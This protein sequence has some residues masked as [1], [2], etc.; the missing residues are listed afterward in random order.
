VGF[1]IFLAFYLLIKS[2]DVD[3]GEDTGLNV[4][5]TIIPAIIYL[6]ENQPGISLGSVLGE[7]LTSGRLLSLQLSPGT[8]CSDLQQSD[9]FFDS[10]KKK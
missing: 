7:D 3:D 1:K 4:R 10:L 5:K 2:L 9:I 8:L 6:Q